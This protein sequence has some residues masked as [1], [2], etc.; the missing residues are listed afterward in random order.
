MGN[1]TGG[2]GKGYG[3]LNKGQRKKGKEIGKQIEMD[4]LIKEEYTVTKRVKTKRKSGISILRIRIKEI[5]KLK[6]GS[7]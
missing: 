2:K 7:M 1:A 3:N 4:C 5:S 6:R